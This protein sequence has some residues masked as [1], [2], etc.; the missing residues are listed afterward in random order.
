MKKTYFFLLLCVFSVSALALDVIVPANMSC[1]TEGGGYADTNRHDS[2]KLS[3]RN[4]SNGNKSWIKFS[5]LASYDLSQVR[6]AYLTVALHEAKAGAQN[7]KVSMVNDNCVENILWVDHPTLANPEQGIY[8]LTWNNAPGNLTTSLGA[9]E[10]TETTYIATI[11]FTDGAAGQS[12]TIDVTD[13]VK[14]DTDGVVQFVLHDSPNLLN[15]A[16]H[17]HATVAWRPYLTLV[18]PPLGADYPNPPDGYDKVPT[19]LAQLSWTN[20]EPNVPGQPIYCDVYLGTEPNRLLM[21]KV[22]LGNNISSVALTPANFP[23]F[24]PLSNYTTYY[25]VVDCYDTTKGKIEGEMWS[26]YTNDNQ[27]PYNVS[28]GADQATWLVDGAASVAL[29]G[30]AQD[31]GLPIPPGQLSYL[32]EQTAGPT[33]AVIGSPN[34]AGTIVSFTEA[35]DYTFRL[36][37]SDGMESVTDTVRVVVGATS[38]AASHVFYNQPYNVADVNQD[39]IVDLTDL[40]LLIVN[41][42]LVCDNTLEACN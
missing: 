1:R 6:A 36:T 35:G 34:T 12:F 40:Q 16:T 3:V 10:P 23:H 18:F 30:S 11:T 21:D 20:P 33:S 4:T 7:C 22:T 41:N 28:A 32:W 2:S 39:C 5:Q 9:L 8:A 25:W 13:A 27:P 17:D 14:A 19:N 29:V 38:C 37:V 42:W 26:F 24:V 31:D 15:F